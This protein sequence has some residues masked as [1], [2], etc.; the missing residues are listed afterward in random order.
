LR[1]MLCIDMG[2]RTVEVF[3][4]DFPWLDLSEIALLKLVRLPLHRPTWP[5]STLWWSADFH[6]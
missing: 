3:S 2:N 1:T 4:L 6:I 5:Y